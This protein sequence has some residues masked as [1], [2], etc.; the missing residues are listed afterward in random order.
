MQIVNKIKTLLD[1]DK[2]KK[3]KA[4]WIVAIEIAI[5]M[6]L[7]SFFLPGGDDLYR[8]YLPFS[9]GCLECGFIPYFAKWVLWP[10]VLFPYNLAWPIWTAISLTGLLMICRV[11]RVNPVLVMMAFPTFGQIW[12]GQIDVL[13]CAGFALAL[14]EKNAYLRGAGLALALIK[15]QFSLIAVIT[16]L[17]CEREFLKVMVIPVVLAVASL[18]VFGMQWPLEWIHNAA[19]NVPIHVWR[20]ASMDLWP[21]GLLFIWTPFLF[22]D[23]RTRFEAGLLVSA[24]STPFVGV[25]SYIIFLVFIR[26]SWWSVPLSYAWLLLYPLW[27]EESM[28]LAWVF[29]LV[30]LLNMIYTKYKDRLKPH[31]GIGSAPA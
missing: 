12:L 2:E 20:L 24:L 1:M 3:N 8:Y 9:G 31:A 13:V 28:R 11:T 23:C 6:V 30:L 27:Q 21:F 19:N 16:L 15:P 10:L 5:L 22:K 4:S 26:K 7:A 29:P 14:L 17:T 18:V 25:Y